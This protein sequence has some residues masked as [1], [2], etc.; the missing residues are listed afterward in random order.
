MK[1]KQK[2]TEPIQFGT[3]GWRAIIAREFTTENVMRVA[4]AFS[5]YLREKGDAGKGIAVSFDTRFLS[6]R[7][8]FQFAEVVASNEIPVWLSKTVTP[9]PVLS[10]VVKNRNL[11]AGVMITASHNSY[12]YNG[13]KFKDAYGGPALPAMTQAIEKNLDRHDLKYHI[14]NIRRFLKE[15]NFLPEYIGKIKTIIDINLIKNNK[16]PVIVDTMHGAGYGM[17]Y[18]ILGKTDFMQAIN[19]QPHP[20]FKG[21]APEPILKNLAKLSKMVFRKKAMLGIATDGDADRFGVLNE[22]GDFVELH[23]LMPILFQYLVEVKKW[24]GNVVRTTSMANTIDKVAA[25]Y[26]TEVV[27]V[28]VGFKNVTEKMLTE[29]VLIGGEESGGFGYNIFIPERDGILSALLLLELLVYYDL[30]IS[31]LVQQ[32]RHRFGPFHYKRIDQMFLPQTLISNLQKLRNNPP[33]KIGQH[34]VDSVNLIDGIKFYFTNDAWMLMRVSQTE[35]LAR[36][37]VGGSAKQTVEDLLSA[38]KDLLIMNE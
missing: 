27:E 26:N 7:F 4:Q 20:M 12:E 19:Q 36:I 8:S 38:G 29:D 22:K 28:P 34:K 30:P 32:L 2:S 16:R 9:T 37:Y 33:D 18:N 6:D 10:F 35:P 3:D 13:I 1:A 17:F 15:D 14:P 31:A 25:S 23:D 21:R 5:D 24:K 11:A